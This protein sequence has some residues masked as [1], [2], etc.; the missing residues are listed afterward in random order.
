MNHSLDSAKAAFE[1]ALA[2]L[3]SGDA[4][5]AERAARA[6]LVQFPDEP[7]FLVVLGTA[8]NRLN[9]AAEAEPALRRALE[10]DP[11]Y[12]KAH[13][14]LA[15]SLLARRRPAD[16]VPALREALVLNPALKSA[17]IALGQA[18]LAAGDEQAATDA[19]DEL[20][21]EHPQMQRLAEAATLHR[22]GRFDEAEDIYRALLMKSPEDVSVLRLFGLLA[23]DAGHYRNAAA[24]LKKAV[25]LAP[26]FQAAW[27]DL[28]KAQTEL[29]D[30]D[31]AIASAR[32]AIDLAP[33]RAGGYVALGNALARSSR[34]D[35]AI[36]S[37]RRAQV[38][39]PDN[40]ELALGLGNVLKTIGRQ[41][42]A[43]A[44]YRDGI[45]LRPDFAE[46]YWS[47]ANLKT[48]C[49]EPSEVRA[50]E[51]ALESGGLPDASVVHLCFAL[52][53]AWEDSGD[54]RKAFGYFRRGNELRRTEEHYDP[55][56][57]DQIGE[58]IR[59]VFSPALVGRF[60]GAGFADVAPIFI[61]GLPRSG[62]TLIEQ[63]LASHSQV[64]ATHE[65]PEGGRLVRFIDRQRIRG[66][67]Y[68]EAVL[69]FSAAALSEIGRRYDR[70]TR[71]YRSGK[72]RFIDKMPNNFATVGLLALAMPNAR[73][74]NA[75]RDPR[76]TCLSCYKQLFAR[77]QPFTYDLMEL[78]DYYLEY[79][80]MI[81]HWHAVL[82]GRVLDV[83]YESVVA[84]LEGQ[85]RR[86]LEF[87]GL[88]WE[89]VCLRF[90][91]TERAVRTASSEQVRRPIYGDA[92]GVWRHYEAELAPLLDVLAPVLDKPG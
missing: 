67:K 25:T 79:R 8:L 68:P 63:I 16:A 19:Y 71:R 51:Q 86:L 54:Y 49:F 87:C 32:R 74:I 76:D 10:V 27:I 81:D 2:L 61:I 15:H 58:R 43:I 56:N 60:Q 28:C 75:R 50:M 22:D 17:R 39:R 91:A 48:F 5:G 14:A 90:Y 66:R 62:S 38:M 72:P 11:G 24:M 18:L 89:E 6:A 47:L 23:L 21:R 59:K 42:E 4:A 3:R 64:E 82:P 13:E 78:G 53:K 41:A 29:H 30:L 84:D 1:Q 52:G 88:H 85:A 65:L 77:G 55:V 73:F 37:Y 7:N 57:T 9:R 69:E 26:A 80:R 12:A 20:M 36:A 45:R 33:D 83:Q 46:L 31:D 44:A 92:I 40:A 34:A 35:F 70:E